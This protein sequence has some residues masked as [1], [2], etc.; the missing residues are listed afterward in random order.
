ML[1]ACVYLLGLQAL[2][3]VDLEQARSE[4]D[5]GFGADLKL[6]KFTNESHLSLPANSF[7]GETAAQKTPM[8]M[9]LEVSRG[10]GGPP[11]SGTGA[12][13]PAN[14]A[15]S[16]GGAGA[17]SPADGD[18]ASAD[19]QATPKKGATES[20]GDVKSARNQA[21]KQLRG[22]LDKLKKKTMATV[23]ASQIQ[24]DAVPKVVAEHSLNR[25]EYREFENTLVERLKV[26]EAWL[27]GTVRQK[28]TSDELEVV[29]MEVVKV[30]LPHAKGEQ[31]LVQVAGTSPAGE[32]AAVP[33]ETAAEQEAAAKQG[34]GDGA[35]GEGTAGK[36]AKQELSLDDL[37]Q[38]AVN[39]HDDIVRAAIEALTF[40]PMESKNLP[41]SQRLF[42]VVFNLH[43]AASMKA[44]EDT[45]TEVVDAKTLVEQ[46]LK[47][48]NVAAVDLK[49]ALGTDEKAAKKEKEEHQ[50]K[51]SEQQ[52]KKLQ[53]R[54]LA[55]RRRIASLK[56][57][58][59]FKC[60]LAEI[61]HGAIQ[62]FN[63]TAS[64]LEAVGAGEVT[65]DTPFLVKDSKEVKEVFRTE[66]SDKD[67][68]AKAQMSRTLV[69][70]AKSFPS[71]S[72]AVTENKVVAPMLVSMGLDA[73]NEVFRALAP[74]RVESRLP[75]FTAMSE[76]VV[77]FG[78][79][80]ESVNFGHE[81][82]LL[83]C[84]R[85]QHDGVCNIMTISATD[86]IRYW[87]EVCNKEAVTWD[88]YRETLKNLTVAEAKA[89]HTKGI[90][91]HHGE[92]EP[93][94]AL[95]IPIG[96]VTGSFVASQSKANQSAVKFPLLPS[97]CLRSADEALGALT[98]L[99][100]QATDAKTI[101]I[102]RDVIAVALAE[103]KKS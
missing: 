65:F 45:T 15:G 98:T 57:S 6:D 13:A 8:Q 33:S 58:T 91:I 75:S 29:E 60:G 36:E 74:S 56:V 44:V 47:S 71:S 30:T 85:L 86:A 90:H 37:K 84:M 7:S 67:T 66:F 101:G 68:S 63:D 5:R 24:L 38:R 50:K 70:W 89:C 4:L 94:M 100:P 95:Y 72:E 93:G 61:G 23:Q 1:L 48:L 16:S 20:T 42:Q 92:F 22:V 62:M 31:P 35:V 21:R 18:K 12:G 41:S 102:L 46:L 82:N 9:M 52:A 64:L 27:G 19:N 25:E 78:A 77:L 43:D 28:T 3:N 99:K 73:A 83:A 96:F 80:K 49:R 26:A 54:E 81:P 10:V 34:E 40:F 59:A 11:P 69:R 2:S 51:L 97:A 14:F 103:Q 79:L 76:S 88:M 53:E 17:E 39:A 55:E 32:G 87:K